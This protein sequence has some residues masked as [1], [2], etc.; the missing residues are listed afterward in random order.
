[1]LKLLQSKI[2]LLLINA[3]ILIL[4]VLFV[5]PVEGIDIYQVLTVFVQPENGI[6]FLQPIVKIV[7]PNV[8]PVQDLL[9]VV[10]LVTMLTK[11]MLPQDVLAKLDLLI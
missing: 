5:L 4:K 10:V 11:E 1:M 6:I 7:V 9:Q 2:T 8:L 3:T